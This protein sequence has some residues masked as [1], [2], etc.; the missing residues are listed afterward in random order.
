MVFWKKNSHIAW[1]S[2]T[3]STF[4]FQKWRLLTG[5]LKKWHVQK[6]CIKIWRAS[7]QLTQ[8]L[9]LRK[10]LESKV[11]SFTNIFTQVFA[12]Q[13]TQWGHFWRFFGVNL[14]TKLSFWKR[15]LQRILKFQKR[16]LFQNLMLC[17]IFDSNSGKW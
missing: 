11:G 7:K 17:K 1:L 12:F 14:P 8:S 9:K 2:D 6:I 13:K 4:Q 10:K 3:F 16:F 15:I 5:W